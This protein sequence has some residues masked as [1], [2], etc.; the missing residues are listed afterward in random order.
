VA[1]LADWT[2]RK[3]ITLSRASGA[4][5]NYQMRL[6]VGESSGASGEDIDC[7][8][9]C[10]SDFDDIRFTTSDGETLL[11][12]WIESISG[13]TP[14]QLAI[15]WIEFDSIGTSATTFYMYYGN[16]A[17]TAASNGS[18]TFIIFDNFERGS[19]GDT[20]GGSWTEIDPHVHIST[21]QEYTGVAGDTRSAKWVSGT[22]PSPE[23]SIPVTASENIAIMFRAFKTDNPVIYFY[24]GD[25]TDYVYFRWTAAEA[26]EHYYSGWI[27]IGS[28]SH[29]TWH[30]FEI[31][32]FNWSANTFDFW[33]DG[34]K[35]GTSCG[36]YLGSS[37]YA[38][39]F[40][41]NGSEYADSDFWLDNFIV[42]N[43]RTTEP[44]WGSWSAQ[45]DNFITELE[46]ACLYLSTLGQ[47]IEDLH[48]LLQAH[49][50]G[51]T[52]DFAAFL[53]ALG[54]YLEDV[55]AELTAAALEYGDLAMILEAASSTVLDN[56]AMY[57]SATDGTVTSDMGLQLSALRLSPAFK[58]I[59]AQRLTSVI[60]EVI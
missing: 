5:T 26:I 28:A 29:S 42:R 54:Q 57:L 34:S 43:Y 30:L 12:Y 55:A 60:S 21:E 10:S 22:N 19:D 8:S 49:D 31:N 27:S 51:A 41:V 38:N 56:L 37:A 13:T 15:I 53:G 52:G 17:A 11:D 36:E 50:G 24:H 46:D 2:Y 9:N 3:S 6:L 33:V 47:G 23:A 40:R 59:T 20:I 25:G 7:E 32:N 16:A 44:A 45:E 4:V 39:V 14:N 58:S 48:L 1:W 18:N 35:I